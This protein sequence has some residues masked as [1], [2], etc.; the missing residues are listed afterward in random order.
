MY[1]LPLIKEEQIQKEVLWDFWAGVCVGG[2]RLGRGATVG[3]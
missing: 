2:W 3:F 1:P